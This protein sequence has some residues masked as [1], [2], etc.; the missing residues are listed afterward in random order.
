[1]NL[2]S[3]HWTLEAYIIHNEA[4]RA[5]DTK[6]ESER[7]RR[8]AEVKSAEEKALRV[9]EQA[10]RDALGLAREIQVYKDEKANELR[11]QIYAER[12]RYATKDDLVAAIDKVQATL[13]PIA[14]YISAQQGGSKGRNDLWGTALGAVALLV[15]LIAIGS[16]VFRS[17]S[18]TSPQVIYAPAP[19]VAQPKA[20]E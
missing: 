9:K 17:E 5:A 16:F 7:D 10:D 13:G 4:M 14:T 20:K 15:S 12:G 8:Y 19:A 18:R 2:P 11:E 3:K 6:F 1:M